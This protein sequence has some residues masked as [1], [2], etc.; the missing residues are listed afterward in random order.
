LKEVE[1]DPPP[2]GQSEKTPKVP[3]PHAHRQRVATHGKYSTILKSKT[4][5]T[6][7]H[8][9]SPP[10]VSTPQEPLQALP[11]RESLRQGHEARETAQGL[12][13][14]RLPLAGGA[15]LGRARPPGRGR[16]LRLLRS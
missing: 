10:A 5:R 15:P 3:S 2:A 6:S 13:A 12:G 4:G 7:P 9:S 8:G 11:K 1:K 16:A 14:H